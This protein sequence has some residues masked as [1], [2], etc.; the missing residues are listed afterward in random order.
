MEANMRLYEYCISQRNEITIQLVNSIERLNGA[1]TIDELISILKDIQY[2]NIPEEQ[3]HNIVLNLLTEENKLAHHSK[4]LGILYRKFGLLEDEDE[5]INESA[6]RITSFHS[7]K[8]LEAEV[9][10]LTWMNERYMPMPDRDIEEQR[11]LLYVGMTRAK[12]ELYLTFHEQFI[13]GKGRLYI[14]AMSYFLREI[15]DYL[16]AVVSKIETVRR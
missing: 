4:W 1:T 14:K 16:S 5:P 6:V 11:R 13:E 12:Q 7:A 3:L 9:V 8:G 15:S 10:Y 2:L